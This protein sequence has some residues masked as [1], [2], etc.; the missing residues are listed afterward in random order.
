MLRCQS[1]QPIES[2]RMQTV[3]PVGDNDRT[4]FQVLYYLFQV[5]FVFFSPPQTLFLDSMK[6]ATLV[7]TPFSDRNTSHPIMAMTPFAIHASARLF[8]SQPR[9]STLEF[10]DVGIMRPQPVNNE[11]KDVA[12]QLRSIYC[13][14]SISSA[15]PPPALRTHTYTLH[16]SVFSFEFYFSIRDT[17]CLVSSVLSSFVQHV[18]G[19]C[20]QKKN[21][22][23]KIWTRA[24]KHLG[25]WGRA[26]RNVYTLLC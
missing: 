14:A 3:E 17:I 2:A 5:S 13:L 1:Y 10:A 22:H 7:E 16:L 23:L 26:G 20:T 18:R 21:T 9:Y 15:T 12:H 4:L 19:L 24:F 25:H 8:L 11:T 6:S